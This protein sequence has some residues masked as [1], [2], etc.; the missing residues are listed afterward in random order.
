MLVEPTENIVIHK[1]SVE[2]GCFILKSGYGCEA[3][4]KIICVVDND[5]DLK[6]DNIGDNKDNFISETNQDEHENIPYEVIPP[7]LET[8]VESFF[9]NMLYE[10]EKVVI[11]TKSNSPSMINVKGYKSHCSSSVG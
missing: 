3:N 10:K 5:D 7:A 1:T 6:D 11:T 4:E 8:D 9:N 2:Y